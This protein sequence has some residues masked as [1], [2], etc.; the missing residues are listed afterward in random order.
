M[1]RGDLGNISDTE[2]KK[3]KKTGSVHSV[4]YTT[5]IARTDNSR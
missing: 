4:V 3:K 2:K 5:L 1:Y